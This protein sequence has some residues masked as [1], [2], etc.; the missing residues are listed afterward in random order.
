[1]CEVAR[2]DELAGARQETEW[3]GCEM[4]EVDGSIVLTSSRATPTHGESV[5]TGK[6]L[7]FVLRGL[8]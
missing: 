1:M 4:Y 2:Y 8:V 3:F 7:A 6:G 5:Q